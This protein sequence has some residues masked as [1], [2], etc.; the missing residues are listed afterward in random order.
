MGATSPEVPGSCAPPSPL[1]SEAQS[2][3]GLGGVQMVR[4]TYVCPRAAVSPHGCTR[5]PFPPSP[6]P[7]LQT[8]LCPFGASSSVTGENPSQPLL[9]EVRPE[10]AVLQ[11][12]L[13]Q[14]PAGPSH[15]GARPCSSQVS[16]PP[17]RQGW[18]ILA[19]R[20]SCRLCGCTHAHG[21]GHSLPVES[22]CGVHCS[23]C[24]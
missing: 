4:Q 2:K 16:G 6:A 12:V 17:V 24:V 8:C 10:P 7:I 19:H 9:P 13:H 3:T 15:L 5:L 1:L 23:L 22:P 11:N 21:V 18:G 20:V 14:I